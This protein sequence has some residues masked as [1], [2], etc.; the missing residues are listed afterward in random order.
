MAG[1][2]G[3]GLF[4][5]LYVDTCADGTLIPIDL[6]EL[7]DAPQVDRAYLRGITG[8]RQPVDLLLMSHQDLRQTLRRKQ[9]DVDVWLQ[10]GAYVGDCQGPIGFPQTGTNSQTPGGLV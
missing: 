4:V 2:A 9:A 3:N 6:L 10:E 8:D 5:R 7:I 1:T